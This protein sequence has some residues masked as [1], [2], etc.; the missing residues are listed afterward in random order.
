VWISQAAIPLTLY[1]STFYE[2]YYLLGCEA[3]QSSR[4]SLTFWEERTASVFRVEEKVEKSSEKQ[5][6]RP[7]GFSLLSNF[8]LGLLFHP[9]DG[10]NKFHCYVVEPPECI[11]S[12]P[13]RWRPSELSLL[14]SKIKKITLLFP[15]H[16]FCHVHSTYLCLLCMSCPQAC[17]HELNIYYIITQSIPELVFMIILEYSACNKTLNVHYMHLVN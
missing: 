3:V 4:S 17:F 12:H 6:Y 11:A 1:N 7:A 2:K 9:D 14:E 13:I 15:V 16:F 10:G 8:L 5:A